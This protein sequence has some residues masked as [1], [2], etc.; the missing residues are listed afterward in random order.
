MCLMHIWG[1]VMNYLEVLNVTGC[2]FL[3]FCWP[4]GVGGADHPTHGLSLGFQ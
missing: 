3:A 1:M 4:V 2:A